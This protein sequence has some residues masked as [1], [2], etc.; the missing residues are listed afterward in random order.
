[1]KSP[2][3][4]QHSCAAYTLYG[5]LQ[6]PCGGEHIGSGRRKSHAHTT[7]V[8]AQVHHGVHNSSQL[9]HRSCSPF[10]DLL[11]TELVGFKLWVL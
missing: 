3:K 9:L 6:F 1:M 5:V 4:K 10:F 2:G 8:H 11:P 7:T